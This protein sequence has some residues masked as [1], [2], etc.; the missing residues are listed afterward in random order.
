MRS[1]TDYSLAIIRTLLQ[2]SFNTL[3]ARR[4]KKTSQ[5]D[6][7]NE[8]EDNNDFDNNNDVKRI[9]A[10]KIMMTLMTITLIMITIIATM[11]MPIIS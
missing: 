8:S 9:N 4:R 5:N 6:G 3:L 1:L 2:P 10:M 11:T 7:D